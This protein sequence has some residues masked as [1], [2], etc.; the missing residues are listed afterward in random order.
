MTVFLIGSE[1]YRESKDEVIKL[2]KRQ[3]ID[4]YDVTR[5]YAKLKSHVAILEEIETLSKVKPCC[6]YL[7]AGDLNQPYDDGNLNLSSV[8]YVRTAYHCKIPLYLTNS[9][10]SDSNWS[11]L[12]EVVDYILTPKEL[13]GQVL[14]MIENQAIPF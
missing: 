8:Q 11:L 6:F 14:Q 9:K 12:A 13:M 5:E 4:V 2:L 10:L 7:V 3:E 1:Q